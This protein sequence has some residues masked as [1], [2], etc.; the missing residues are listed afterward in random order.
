MP[1]GIC[2]FLFLFLFFFNVLLFHVRRAQTLRGEMI[3]SVSLYP[4]TPAK[5]VFNK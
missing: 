1:G 2:C 5:Q 4:I 3:F